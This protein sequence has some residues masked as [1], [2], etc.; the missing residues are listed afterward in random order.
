MY[1][2][3][4]KLKDNL[5]IALSIQ[6]LADTYMYTNRY[7]QAD[8]SFTKAFKILKATQ[9][10]DAQTRLLIQHIH[11]CLHTR[12]KTE[13][14]HYLGLADKLVDKLDSEEKRNYVFL[15]RCYRTLYYLAEGETEQAETCLKQAL[16]SNV[17]DR[18][19]KQ[20]PHLL[21]CYYYL[22]K[23]EYEK[24]LLY[25]D[26]TLSDLKRNNNLNGY[27]N[28]LSSKASTLET[29]KRPEEAFSI[30]R[31]INALTDSMD[32]TKYSYQLNELRLTYQ[33]EQAK[34]DTAAEYN[35][36]LNW[37]VFFCILILLAIVAVMIILK[38]KNHALSIAR[39]ELKNEMKKAASSIQ[40]KTL[41]L[42]NMSHEIRTPLNG[43][44]GFSDLLVNCKDLD[45]ETKQQCGDNI[46]QNS[47]LLV[48][49]ISDVM[50]LSGL[51]ENEMAFVFTDCD[52]VD[53]CRSVIDTVKAV[54][55]SP[56][57]LSF[58]CPFSHLMLHTDSDRLK[59]VLINLLVNATKFT[60]QGTIRLT[61][62]VDAD[63]KEAVFTVEDTGCGIPLE[64]QKHI[65]DRFEK[66]HEGVQGSGLGLSICQLVVER[67]KGRIWIDAGY[68]QGARFIFTHPLMNDSNK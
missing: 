21:Y 14:L 11:V 12:K 25:A 44:V 20:W 27:I 4:G 19:R 65:F 68:T 36:L 23:G 2:E 31:Q 64:K 13:M 59:Q 42:S 53:I 67:V 45:M 18:V 22:S 41:F 48:K 49:L 10:N 26:S 1:K 46:R 6:A 24:S 63:A 47:E 7:E 32:A 34:L 3:A 35:N 8:S 40:S 9:D 52:V 37:F 16:D 58:S 28:F 57:E 17:S 15:L 33:I 51:E 55:K 38:R 54:K 66:L 61:L 56:A 39:D 60:R 62:H 43:I 29:I 5:G 30:Y 50:D